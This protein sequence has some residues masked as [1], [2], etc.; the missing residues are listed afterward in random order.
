MTRLKQALTRSAARLARSRKPVP[1]PECGPGEMSTE[2]FLLRHEI[3]G[4]WEK[5]KRRERRMR[6]SFSPW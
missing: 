5:W 4:A 1:V 6:W 3:E 2:E